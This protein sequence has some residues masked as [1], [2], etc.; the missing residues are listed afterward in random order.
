MK[1]KFC[2]TIDKEC[3][4]YDKFNRGFWCEVC[5]GYSYL[6]G[7]NKHNFILILEDKTEGKTI[8][9]KHSIKLK[10]QISPLRYPGGKSKLI[11]YIY[12]K[13]NPNK[14]DVFIEPF[15]GG[16]SVGLSLLEAKVINKLILNDLDFGIYSL[17]SIIKNNPD[18]LIEKINNHTPTHE[19]YYA[20]Q[21]NIKNNYKGCGVFKS[22]WSLLLVN[23][24]AY[25][26]IFKAGPLGGKNGNAD[27]LLIRW[28]P[29]T[30]TKRIKAI[31]KMSDR[32][33]ALNM[34]AC[35]LI[36]EAYW[37]EQATI[38]I[39][40]PYFRKGKDLYNHYYNE[41]EHIKLSVLLD[42]LYQGVPGA[43]MILTYN[44]DR[45]IEW[46]YLYPDIEKINR[47]YVI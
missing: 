1:C 16:A 22:A 15:A 33:T 29:K 18:E 24:L 2:N 35:E 45:F 34:D 3:F 38:F 8:G 40:P 4:E 23:R 10:K 28:S 12:S 41:K 5:D 26:G 30:L 19:D 17:F 47:V 37:N 21:E 9:T 14:T 36:M 39:D 11:D 43:D 32:I 27:D 44:N 7:Q 46:L 42:S 6:G 25:S 31:N 13:M 20:A